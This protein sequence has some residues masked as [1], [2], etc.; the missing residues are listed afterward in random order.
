[1][2][3]DVTEIETYDEEVIA[4]SA[5]AIALETSS[6]GAETAAPGSEAATESVEIGRE[7]ATWRAVRPADAAS[8]SPPGSCS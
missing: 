7:A 2:W 1:M 5:A 4:E 8:G 6:G 3:T